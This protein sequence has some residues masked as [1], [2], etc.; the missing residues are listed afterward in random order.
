LA[1]GANPLCLHA[2]IQACRQLG[3]RQFELQR[4]DA[5]ERKEK[6]LAIL[7][8]KAQ[9]G[10]GLVRV[11]GFQTKPPLTALAFGRAR[12]LLRLR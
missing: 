8:Y 3:I 7:K 2:A 10:G 4:F 1:L 12:G 6:E 11:G 5:R 9:F